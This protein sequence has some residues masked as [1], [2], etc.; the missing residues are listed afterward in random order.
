MKYVPAQTINGNRYAKLEIEDVAPEVEY[1]KNAVI[2]SVL[3]A[4]PP[5]EVVK[6]YI[7]CI[8]VAYD[9]DQIVQ[10][11]KGLF[12]V[13]FIQLQDKVEVEKKGLYYFDRK[14]FLVKGWT[15]EM[16]LHTEAIKSLPLWV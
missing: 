11:I 5:Y 1:W 2:C 15:R 9:I 8:R 14:P 6:G 13:R 3:G 10:V 4:N 12:L 16:D 7:K